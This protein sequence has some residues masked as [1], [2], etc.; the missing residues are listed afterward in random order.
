MDLI[1]ELYNSDLLVRGFFALSTFLL[2]LTRISKTLF[3]YTLYGKRLTT[4]NR[5]NYSKFL[6]PKSLFS[7]FYVVGLISNGYMFYKFYCHVKLSELRTDISGSKVYKVPKGGPFN[8][9]LCP[10]YLAEILIYV[11]LSC[12]LNMFVS[13]HSS[14]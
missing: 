12:N 9:V 10:H 6:V 11:S 4:S 1:E 13:N 2:L 8:F 7:T 14:F 5:Y 3:S